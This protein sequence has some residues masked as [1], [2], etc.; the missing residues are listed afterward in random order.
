LSNKHKTFAKEEKDGEV[1]RLKRHIHHLEKENHKL[2]SEL[3]T[4]EAA[5]KKN[6]VFLKQRTED[7]SLEELI[8]GAEQ[9]FSLQEIKQEKAQKFEDLQKKW[10]CF[11]C[12]EGVMKLIIIPRGA[13]TSNYFRK[14]NN[15][16]CK[17]RTEAKEY[18]E[19]V[20]GVK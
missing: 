12:N 17:N 8:K 14:C 18:N 7:L 9:E 11:T 3:R 13:G 19:N 6:I 2:K 20:E 5:F 1:G 4:Y 15:P 10:K 16:K